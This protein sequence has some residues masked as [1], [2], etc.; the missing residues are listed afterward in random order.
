MMTDYVDTICPHCDG[1]GE[2]PYNDYL[3][4]CGF[5]GGVGRIDKK[6]LVHYSA[7]IKEKWLVEDL[8]NDTSI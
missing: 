7:F 1:G 8:E 2:E 6:D 3:T 4:E 5:C